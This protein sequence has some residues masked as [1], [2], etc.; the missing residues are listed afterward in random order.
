MFDGIAKPSPIL[1]PDGDSICELMPINS[2]LVLT[3]AP[4]ELPRFIGASVC[5]KSSKLPLLKPVCR[6]FA[7][8]IP[9]VTVWP[10]PSGFPIA[11]TTSPTRVRSESPNTSTGNPVAFDFQHRQIARRIGANNLRLQTA[12]VI[13]INF[14]LIRAIDHVMICQDVTILVGRLR[15][16]PNPAAVGWLGGCWFLARRRTGERKDRS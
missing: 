15:L 10:T 5:R 12:V 7:L 8:M 9:I 13:Q 3:S 4:P 2:P 6:P 11:S 14:D 16:N 1:P